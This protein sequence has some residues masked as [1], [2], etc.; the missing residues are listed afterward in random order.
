MDKLGLFWKSRTV[1]MWGD[2]RLRSWIGTGDGFMGAYPWHFASNLFLICLF[3]FFE[4]CFASN[5]V[6]IKTTL[7]DMQYI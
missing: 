6:K 4:I 7:A 2:I 3:L 1:E 5:V